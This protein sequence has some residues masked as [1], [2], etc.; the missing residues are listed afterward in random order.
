MQY[1]L[2]LQQVYIPG[3]AKLREAK[4]VIIPSRSTFTKKLSKK[5][6][7]RDGLA[8]GEGVEPAGEKQQR[9]RAEDFVSLVLLLII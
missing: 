6:G 3:G 1:G 7:W 8:D 5:S 9:F 2:M 4:L